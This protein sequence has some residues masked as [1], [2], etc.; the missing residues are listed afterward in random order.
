MHK[1]IQFNIPCETE[2]YAK[3]TVKPRLTNKLLSI[4][5]K[6]VLAG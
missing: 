5:H 4:V 2:I 6:D 3:L 1:I